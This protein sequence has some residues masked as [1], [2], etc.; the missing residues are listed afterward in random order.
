MVDSIHPDF[1]IIPYPEDIPRHLFILKRA[2]RL[3]MNSAKIYLPVHLIVF[4]LR[5]RKAKGIKLQIILRGI[6]ELIGSCL[7]A[8]CFALS[9]PASYSYIST[10]FPRTTHTWI[11]QVVGLIFSFAIFF[12]SNS[13]WSE[14]SI[15]VFAQWL[16]GFT[17][18]L[19]KRKYAPVI[20]HW[21]VCIWI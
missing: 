11:G 7:F 4:L 6:R 19:Y 15:Y 16:E 14:I 17:Y 10:V 5:I 20:S 3:F 2:T 21:E 9:I 18:S 13:R 12:D 8:S 1:R